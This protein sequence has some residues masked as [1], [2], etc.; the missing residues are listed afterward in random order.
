MRK[1]IPK[2]VYILLYHSVVDPNQRELWEQGYRKGETTILQ[3]QE[4]LKFMLSHMPAVALSELPGLWA[5]GSLEKSVFAVTFDDGFTNNL[6]QAGPIIQQLGLHPTVFVC[7]EFARKRQSLYRVL[8][9]V[10][11]LKGY[12]ARL[13]AN[14]RAQL[15]GQDWPD[16]G[17]ALQSLMKGHYAADVMEEVTDA[18]YRECLGDPNHLNVHLDRDGVERLHRAGWEIGNHTRA[19]R[20]LSHQTPDQV[21]M[22]IEDNSHYWEQ[23]KIPLIHF[24]AYPVGRAIDVGPGVHAWLQ[25]YPH[26]HG[27]FG[28][29]G[30]NFSLRRNEWLRF[31][32]GEQTSWDGC[33]KIMLHQIRRTQSAL[34]NL[35]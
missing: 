18:T 12:A 29:G 10:L 15:P 28:N 9:G 4:Q 20:L 2:G 33:E 16:D 8:A 22:A 31:S 27:M 24:L 35:A 34:E 1:K 30:I 19:H 25:R 21:A 26:M 3:L 32:L 11:V 23:Q 17:A 14:L 5:N 6:T 13:A 7:S